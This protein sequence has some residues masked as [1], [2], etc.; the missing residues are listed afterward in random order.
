M[1]PIFMN[2]FF[3]LFGGTPQ[4]NCCQYSPTSMV[5]TYFHA[6]QEQVAYVASSSYGCAAAPS[7]V[8]TVQHSHK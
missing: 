4:Y 2:K 3:T 7:V 8:G 1:F 6:R 5:I